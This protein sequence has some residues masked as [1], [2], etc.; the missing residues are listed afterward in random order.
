[1]I[2]RTDADP[3]YV[4]R[5]ADFGLNVAAFRAKY[6][7]E[8]PD[9]FFDIAV[10]CCKITPDDRSVASTSTLIFFLQYIYLH[11]SIHCESK[12]NCTLFVSN[13][14]LSNVDRF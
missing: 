6:G 3:D 10:T 14:T 5:L 9:Q 7:S 8:C 12:K 2:G 13:I 1:M 4:P 11:V